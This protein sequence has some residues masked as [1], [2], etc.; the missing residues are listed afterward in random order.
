MII[1]PDGEAKHYEG[2]Q[3][4]NVKTVKKKSTQHRVS[5]NVLTVLKSYTEYTK[6]GC[7]QQIV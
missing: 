7:M 5:R 3:T 2:S 6:T 4:E 1:S